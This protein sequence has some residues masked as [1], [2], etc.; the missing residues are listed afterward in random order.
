MR[1]PTEKKKYSLKY[2][3]LFAKEPTTAIANII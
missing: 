3:A 2:K 1:A